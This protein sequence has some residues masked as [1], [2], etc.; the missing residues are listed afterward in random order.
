MGKF[1]VKAKN[2]LASMNIGDEISESDFATLTPDGQFVQLEYI[3]DQDSSDMYEVHPGIFCIQKTMTGFKLEPTTFVK[4]SILKTFIHTETITTRIDC[5]FRNLHRYKEFGIEVPSRKMMLYGPPGVGK[6]T[7]IN[8]L[9]EEY[10]KDKKTLVVV[11]PTDKF[12]AFHVKDFIKSFSYTG[13]IEKMIL[14]VEDLGGVEIDK[15]SMKADSSLLSLLDNQEKT[16]KLPVLILATT[17]HPEIFGGALT[18]RPGRFDDKIHIGYPPGSYRQDLFNFF[19]KDINGLD[20]LDIKDT[21]ELM[22][23][24][25]TKEFSTAH[26]K[27]VVIR[28][29]IYEKLMCDVVRELATEQ[30]KYKKDFMDKNGKMGIGSFDD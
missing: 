9:A 20:P 1:K 26:I 23:S 3:E 13:G 15:V 6:T 21:L 22:D 29:A 28:S 16:F 7:A 8:G 17:N 14:I 2:N 4:D 10:T 5:F 19:I 25:L 18:N 27:E 12:E 30:E 24:N 11:W